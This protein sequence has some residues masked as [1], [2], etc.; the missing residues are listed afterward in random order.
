MIRGLTQVTWER[1]DV[2]FHKSWLRYNA[3]NNIQV[4]IHPVNSDGEDVIYHMIDNFL[5]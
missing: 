2:C 1:V 3:H 5:V 4:R